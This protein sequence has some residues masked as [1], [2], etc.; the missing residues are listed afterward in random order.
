ML[1]DD[2][3]LSKDSILTEYRV[4]RN[5]SMSIEDSTLT[6]DSIYIERDNI[7]LTED[8]VLTEVSI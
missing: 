6:E 7:K 8:R 4:L 5:V 3:I 2:N 1:I